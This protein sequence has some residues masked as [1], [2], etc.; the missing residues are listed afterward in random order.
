MNERGM[1]QAGNDRSD[2]VSS[3]EGQIGLENLIHTI[4][5][6][7][8]SALRQGS[9]LETGVEEDNI[10]E[11]LGYFICFVLAG[12]AMAIPLSSVQEAGRLNILQ[13]LPL[14]PDWIAG[15]TMIR[16]EIVSVVNLERFLDKGRH[17]PGKGHP[18][19]VIQGRDIKMA[20]TVDSI[21]G[22]R[23]LYRFDGE[24]SD[25]DTEPDFSSRF[26]S[27]RA[28][29]QE[30]D[31]EKEIVFFDVQTFLSSQRLRNAATA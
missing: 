21:I 2:D 4:D 16:G 8:F 12:E 31:S 11:Y 20:V 23:S 28:A 9:E 29:Y 26:V 15:I 30:R 6:D 18:Y 22:T 25:Q 24:R 17:D 27:G 1:D 5:R 14:L 13:K 7:I 3:G 10:R 19:L